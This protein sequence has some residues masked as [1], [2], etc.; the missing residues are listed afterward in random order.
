MF[1]KLVID[2]VIHWEVDYKVEGFRFDIMGHLM[3]DTMLKIR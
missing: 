2:D 3:L 1:E